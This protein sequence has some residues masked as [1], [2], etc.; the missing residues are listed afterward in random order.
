[1]DNF[2]QQLM[3]IT[4]KCHFEPVL[5]A[6]KNNPTINESIVVYEKCKSLGLLENC[7][8]PEILV[9]LSIIKDQIVFHDLIVKLI[10]DILA[11]DWSKEDTILVFKS[12]ERCFLEMQ[13]KFDKMVELSNF[14]CG[15]NE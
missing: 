4:V 7:N 12:M 1:M 15:D 11:L 14:L 10:E 3:A 8:D 9:R 5:K 13:K 2:G 6:L